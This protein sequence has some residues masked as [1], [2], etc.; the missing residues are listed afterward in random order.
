MGEVPTLTLNVLVV[1]FEIANHLLLTGSEDLGYEC[2]EELPSIAHLNVNESG[3]TK[4]TRREQENVDNAEQ[5]V[6]GKLPLF[7]YFL[8]HSSERE[9]SSL[10]AYDIL[11]KVDGWP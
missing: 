8:L 4:T 11:V 2:S 9:T 5:F 7:T 3:I 1:L 10:D 6:T